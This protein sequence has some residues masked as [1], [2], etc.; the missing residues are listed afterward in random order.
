LEEGSISTSVSQR[1]GAAWA[2]ARRWHGQPLG[3]QKV[4]ERRERL[5]VDR[6]ADEAQLFAVKA[7]VAI[8]QARGVGTEFD[9]RQDARGLGFEPERQRDA[10][11]R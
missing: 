8:G 10:S 6:T 11:I 5:A 4:V 9:A 7:Q 1:E 3:R 2:G